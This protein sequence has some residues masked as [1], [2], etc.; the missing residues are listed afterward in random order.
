MVVLSNCIL[1]NVDGFYSRL[2]DDARKIDIAV[3][4]VKRLTD[5][6]LK[7]ISWAIEEDVKSTELMHKATLQSLLT[8][9][10]EERIAD[11]DYIVVH[12]SR[13]NHET[14]RISFAISLGKEPEYFSFSRARTEFPNVELTVYGEWGCQY[15]KVNDWNIYTLTNLSKSK[16]VMISSET[17]L[18]SD[19][20]YMVVRGYLGD[21]EKISDCNE[22][23]VETINANIAKLADVAWTHDEV[24][25]P[26][27]TA[28][29]DG[30][31]L[32]E[33]VVLNN[34]NY[35]LAEN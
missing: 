16:F 21:A 22:I 7:V 17:E 3:F 5:E 27:V 35:F 32:L 12:Y 4:H 14:G 26:T 8:S 2:Q 11:P 1:R 10:H 13:Y 15:R 24:N 33:I 18:F 28:M 20:I 23:S 31:A 34:R 29:H 30:S 6:D 19:E 9:G 25:L